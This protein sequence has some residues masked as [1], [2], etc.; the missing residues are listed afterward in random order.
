M[1][2][3]ILENTRCYSSD[4]LSCRSWADA[5]EPL[6]PIIDGKRMGFE[7][8]WKEIWMPHFNKLLTSREEFIKALPDS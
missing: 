8:F 7:K 4:P 2:D 6:I 3:D 5:Y 1:V